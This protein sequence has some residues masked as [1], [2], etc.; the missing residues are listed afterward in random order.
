MDYAQTARKAAIWLLA[1]IFMLQLSG[2]LLLFA[3]MEKFFDVNVYDAS[4][5]KNGVYPLMQTG[6]VGMLTDSLPP[7]Y[8]GSVKA[9]MTAAITPQYMRSQ[10]L[11]ILSQ[12][13][14]YISGKSAKMELYFD[15]SPVAQQ[16]ASSQ[17]PV[18]QAYVSQ[19]GTMSLA[20]NN[21]LQSTS[22]YMASDA[23]IQQMRQTL[24]S[25]NILNIVL[26]FVAIL[27]LALIFFLSNDMKAGMV[28]CA[29]TVFATGMATA[30][31]GIAL[32]Y[33]TAPM[34][35]SAVN[36]ML[37]SSAN[38]GQISSIVIAIMGDVFHE[39]GMLTVL[40]SLPLILI[41]GA[42]LLYFKFVYKDGA[43]K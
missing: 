25:L 43:A 8:K 7:E 4:L 33:L 5:T 28:K 27:E 20:I 15:I 37:P 2:C 34:L 24:P 16:L 22:D 17:N 13:L 41:G 19:T 21:A 11:P 23:S 29:G 12:M 35:N 31:S 3:F 26:F 32:A 9:E 38:A 39:I 36:S 1:F 42:I 30:L 40:L 14:A 18:V 6:L 10:M